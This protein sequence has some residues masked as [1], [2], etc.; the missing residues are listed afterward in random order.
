MKKKTN[1]F[2]K[3]VEFFLMTFSTLSMA[4]GIYIFCFPNNFTFGG[5]TGIAVILSEIS[6]ISASTY[7]FII[8][9]ALIVLGFIFLGKK[10]G[11]KTVYAS[12]L[13]SATISILNWLVPITEPLTDEPVLE[14]VFAIG[15]PSFASAILFNIG[16]SSGGTDIVAMILKKY[17]NVNIATSLFIVDLVITALSCF[18]FDIKTGLYSFCG[19]ICKSLVIDVVIENVN[20]CKYFTIVCT[21]P[22]PICYFIHNELHRSATKFNAEGS[23]SH[24]QEF[25]I[26][27]VLKR[28]QAVSLRNFI[29]DNQPSAFIMITNSSEIIGKGFRGF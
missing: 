11:I 4:A 17:V 28:G 23:Y 2:K 1:F 6:D 19:L 7:T 26:L 25:V 27:T 29:K 9:M 15:I 16:A 24:K 13:F 21:D 22:D 18:V 8:N 10:S 14:L 3:T 20:L 12:I 5:V